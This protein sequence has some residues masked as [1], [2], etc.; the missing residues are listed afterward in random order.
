MVQMPAATMVTLPAETVHTL[1][2]CDE[3]VTVNVELAV[4][5][6][7]NGASWYVFAAG[8]VIGPIVCE[9][10]PMAMSFVT[11]AAAR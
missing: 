3:N 5:F 1:A 6:T 9:A 11:C 8:A 2:V 4:A 10:L 7:G